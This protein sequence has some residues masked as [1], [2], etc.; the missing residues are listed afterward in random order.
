M[1]L[2]P[3]KWERPAISLTGGCDSKTTLACARGNYEKYTY[4]SYDSQKNEL[5]D[6]SREVRKGELLF[7]Q[8][9]PHVD[10]A[11]LRTQKMLAVD[12]LLYK[13]QLTRRESMGDS[14]LTREKI[15]SDVLGEKE[16]KRRR[17]NLVHR[18]AF[19]GKFVPRMKLSAGAWLPAGLEIGEIHSGGKRVTAYA[20][21]REVFKLSPGAK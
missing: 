8:H 20:T 21:D 3:K 10:F 2:I 16:L 17:D 18:A 9:S 15:K 5:P 7:E 19:D 11:I 4:F 14:I 1:A 12:T 6:A 13:M